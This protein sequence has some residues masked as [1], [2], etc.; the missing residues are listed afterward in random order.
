MARTLRDVL[1]EAGRL[2][3]KS[4]KGF[5]VYDENRNKSPDPE[6]EALIRKVWRRE[7]NPNE[8]YK[9]RRDS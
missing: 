5:Y 1:C 6:V 4:G 9:Q 8:R 7:T 2:G 3:Q